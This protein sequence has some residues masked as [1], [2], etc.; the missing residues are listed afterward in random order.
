MLLLETPYT[1]LVAVQQDWVPWIPFGWFDSYRFPTDSVIRHV[2][3]PVHLFHG[4]QDGV[5]PY[6]HS[7][8]LCRILQK[9]A[10]TTIPGGF[11][12]NLSEYPAY[13]RALDSCL[14]H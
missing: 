3:C 9:N 7:Q 1:N 12:K 6:T 10:L 13:H 8:A 14:A 5:I 11:H 4:T 2:Q